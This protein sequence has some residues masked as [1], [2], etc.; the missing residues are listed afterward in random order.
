M[1]HDP[2]KRSRLAAAEEV[3]PYK[4]SSFDHTAVFPGAADRTVLLAHN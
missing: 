4:R 2:E 1:H 3:P